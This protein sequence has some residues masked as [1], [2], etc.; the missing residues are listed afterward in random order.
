M[1]TTSLEA[2]KNMKPK[3]PTDHELILAVLSDEKEMTYNEIAKE[4][5]I[6]LYAQNK[7]LQLQSWINPNKVSRRMK[8]LVNKK[9]VMV[10]EPR[11]CT[12]VKSR[13]K[14]YLLNTK[15]KISRTL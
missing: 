8:E 13:C 15:G 5:R 2:Y 6:S 11:L 1:E 12:I 7:T 4:V 10:S 9:K 3:I 14:T